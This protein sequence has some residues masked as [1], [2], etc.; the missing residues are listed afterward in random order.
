MT[1]YE[2]RL[3]R[4]LERIR[5]LVRTISTAVQESVSRAAPALI[6]L[7][8]DQAA[9][10][11]LSDHRV[12]RMV[13]ECDR[14][15]HAFVAR[16]L[17]SAGHLRFVSSVLRI[18]VALERVGDYAVTISRETAQLDEPPP[19]TVTRDIELMSES[20]GRYLKQA[21]KAFLE[22]SVDLARATL[23]MGQQFR[24]TFER[25]F[26]DLINEAEQGSRKGRDLFA[27][28]I[29]LNRLERVGD[30]AKNICEEAIFAAS[31]ETKR[32]R[33]YRVLFLDTLN[34]R[35]SLMAHCIAQKAFP[36]SGVY[37][38]AGLDPAP[39]LDDGFRAFMRD[40]G[41]DLH[42]LRPRPLSAIHED[43]NEVD[44]IVD[45]EGT[46]RE[47][48][49]RLPFHTVLVRWNVD[50]VVGDLEALHGT[51]NGRVRDLMESLRGPDAA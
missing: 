9:A 5:E 3:E 14:L 50:D 30:Q 12:N 18:C 1:H 37:S 48:L 44:V 2:E 25:F 11:I 16:H 4:D 10:I 39:T 20:V 6:T 22:S 28:L 31:G 38:S 40:H 41:L 34:D 24:S 23:S 13:R 46:A 36:E 32:P 49:G 19:A 33:R 47:R 15:C 8:R 51:L 26:D 27:L 17:P 43:L 45:L 42:D 7:D 21:C 35:R 29:V